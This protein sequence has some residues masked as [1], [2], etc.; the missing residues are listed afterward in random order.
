MSQV[1]DDG[2][3]DG[4]TIQRL[5]RSRPSNASAVFEAGVLRYFCF[6]S[7][8]ACR[9]KLS[10]PCSELI[11]IPTVQFVPASGRSLSSQLPDIRVG[12]AL[13]FRP[14]Q[15]LSFDEQSLAFISLSSTT[16]L[17]HNRRKPGV[18]AGASG[19]SRI[20]GR[21]EKKMVQICAR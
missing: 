21:E 12:Q 18:F 5:G 10:Y 2:Q 14:L 20:S 13:F 15:S 11:Y 1:S 19:Q 7:S 3:P 9:E 8:R 16:P 17:Q 6:P 4:L